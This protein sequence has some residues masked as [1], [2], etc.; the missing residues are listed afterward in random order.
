M[1]EDPPPKNREGLGTPRE[2]RLEGER[3]IPWSGSGEG[4]RR[5][6]GAGG[7]RLTPR[8]SR[9]GAVPRGAKGQKPRRFWQ[10]N[11]PDP[12]L[13]AA[14][15]PGKRRH[16]KGGEGRGEEEGATPPQSSANKEGQKPPAE[17]N[18]SPAEG[19]KQQKHERRETF[20][21]KEPSLGPAERDGPAEPSPGTAWGSLRGGTLRGRGPRQVLGRCWGVRPCPELLQAVRGRFRRGGWSCG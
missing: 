19:K 11:R 13:V 21:Q 12:S 5:E 6:R 10:G 1:G 17:P 7:L 4:K 18:L 8:P 9:A 2:E 16:P 14:P 3:K 15:A 20:T